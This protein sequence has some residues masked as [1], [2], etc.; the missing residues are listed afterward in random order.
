[1]GHAIGHWER[2]TLVV[3]VPGFNQQSWLDNYPHVIERYHRRE[4]GH[5][6]VQILIDEP[7]T[8]FKPWKVNMN[9]DLAP[10]E[11]IL[12][13]ACTENNTYTRHLPK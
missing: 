1:M 4:F 2:D 9:W 12:E 10:K 6:D 7:G 3:D 5:M 13:N 8:F 11:D